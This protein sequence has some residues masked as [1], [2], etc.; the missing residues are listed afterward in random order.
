MRD[1]LLWRDRA[2]GLEARLVALGHK[3]PLPAEDDTLHSTDLL[4]AGLDCH[5]SD[6]ENV[7]CSKEE[8]EFGMVNGGSSSKTLWQRSQQTKMDGGDDDDDNT[9]N[10]SVPERHAIYLETLTARFPFV[11]DQP[12]Q[13]RTKQVGTKA[14]KSRDTESAASAL[15][16]GES[17]LGEG[18]AAEATQGGGTKSTSRAYFERSM[19]AQQEISARLERNLVKARTDLR[20]IYA[21]HRNNGAD[22]DDDSDYRNGG[23]GGGETCVEEGGENGEGIFLLAKTPRIGDDTEYNIRSDGSSGGVEPQSC[24]P[25][26]SSVEGGITSS[27]HPR[28][29][30]VNTDAKSTD[31]P[32]NISGP[33]MARVLTALLGGGTQNITEAT[34]SLGLLSGNTQRGA[35]VHTER[36]GRGLVG[37]NNTRSP[38]A[39]P[40]LRL[41]DYPPLLQAV[42][43]G[44]PATLPS[45]ARGTSSGRRA[46]AKTHERVTRRVSREKGVRRQQASRHQGSTFHGAASAKGTKQT[47]R[48]SSERPSTTED[49]GAESQTQRTPLPGVAR[50]KGAAPTDHVSKGCSV[51]CDAQPKGVPQAV[52]PSVEPGRCATVGA[53]LGYK[54]QSPLLQRWLE[55]T[56][57]SPNRPALY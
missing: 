50:D 25:S 53:F 31:A 57:S 30:G 4:T 2:K 32:V 13:S 33:Y 39:P 44:G 19:Q 43:S 17:M 37:P 23:G 52:V 15:F 20:M 40:S 47:R 36:N 8:E 26:S 7:P 34:T 9:A 22:D 45:P 12:K 10:L 16:L 51:V 28:P 41:S 42:F 5:M 46:A 29:T 49:N 6:V 11:A 54:A 1:F 27:Q 24:Q 56:C 18:E 55:E 21:S 14:S 3:Q 35:N 38:P 48:L